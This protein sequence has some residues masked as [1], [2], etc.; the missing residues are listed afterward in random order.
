MIE[1]ASTVAVA[2]RHDV[3]SWLLDQ[4]MTVFAVF[5]TLAGAY[6]RLRLEL[7][8]RG[9]SRARDAQLRER[10]RIAADIHDSLGHDLTLLSLQ[11]AAIQVKAVEPEIRERAAAMRAGAADAIATVRRLV[12]LLSVEHSTNVSDV[13]QRAR[14]AGMTVEVSGTPPADEF[15]GRL[16]G[17]ALSNAARHAPGEPVSIAFATG[18][19]VEISNPRPGGP[20][21]GGASPPGGAG[22]PAK[23][24]GN[25]AASV[26]PVRAGTGLAALAARLMHAGG[27]LAVDTADGRFRLIAQI[28][29]GIDARADEG[30]A[31]LE[32]DF[33][34]RR[35]R[36][37]VA[38][39]ATVLAPLVS[40][41]VLSTGFYSWAAHDATIEPAT[42]RRLHIG[43][44]E[45][46]AL[47]LLPRRQA[48]IRFGNSQ[49]PN[50]RYYT[51][52]NYPLAYGN[53]EICFRD[54]RISALHDS[55]GGDA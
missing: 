23:I 11:A 3:A 48:P 5:V 21:A 39:T 8:M 20:V 25:A 41:G 50:C 36:A 24:D 37:R 13:V 4:V 40:L 9:W 51:D 22:R 45:Q 30:S 29:D 38:L 35:R 42:Y 6:R 17:E 49:A 7:T 31:S 26:C 53:Y 1:I 15:T 55:T 46:D 12:D 54:S 52:G 32:A 19:R 27:S 10:A 14:N 43:M 34:S 47:A 44:S 16:V 18:G 33:D 28:P 2:V